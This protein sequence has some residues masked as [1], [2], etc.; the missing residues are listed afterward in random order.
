MQFKI[1]ISIFFERLMMIKDELTKKVFYYAVL[2]YNK[3]NIKKQN[4]MD[5]WIGFNV[6]ER[7]L[8][9]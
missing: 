4:E 5:P 1:F 9:S 6:E 3:Y 8:Y 7:I 2:K